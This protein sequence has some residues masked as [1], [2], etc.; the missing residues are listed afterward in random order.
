MMNYHKMLLRQ[1]KKIGLDR[2]TTP[3]DINKWQELVDIV[4]Q[5]YY[6]HDQDR[7]LIERSLDISSQ[8]MHVL[9][10]KLESAH[11]LVRFGYVCY[12]VA[13]KKITM[14]KHAYLMFG[15]DAEY[16]I[17][18]LNDLYLTVHIDQRKLFIQFIDDVIN[19]QKIG[20]CEIQIKDS[21]HG[22]IYKWYRIV[23]KP[24]M[25]D[26]SSAVSGLFAVMLDITIK[27]AA[28]AELANLQQELILSARQ[29]GMTD[30]ATSMLH[31]VGNILNSANVSIELINEN[32]NDPII[33]NLSSLKELIENH[34]DNLED[35]FTCDEKGK[36][37]PQYFMALADKINDLHKLIKYEV[38]N[39]DEKLK[40]IKDIT[41][42]QKDISG[43]AD[44]NEKVFIKQT[45]DSAIMM[46]DPNLN[47]NKIKIIRDY[48]N[49]ISI[50]SDRAKI[51]QILV[52][53]IKNAEDALL[54]SDR[55][56]KTLWITCKVI[57]DHV[58][59][60]I[61]DNGCGISHENLKKIYI[62]GFTTKKHG[63]GFG[64]HSASIVATELGG[65][66]TA[67]SDGI[68]KGSCFT[69]ILP[70]DRFSRGEKNDSKIEFENH[71]H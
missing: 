27:K 42:M 57:L 11:E 71:S 19:S 36:L 58:Q 20:E 3:N 55:Q 7:N 8:E 62:Y 26:D 66:L 56:E 48:A 61:K 15:C 68:D 38:A 10:S 53:F 5:S 9:H 60:S 44:M 17:D 32:L 31:N 6:I 25:K 54:S 13:I 24:T 21:P 12:D 41:A 33:N 37:F 2:D 30:V 64:L 46:S 14:S 51:L 28:D 70:I 22:D 49:D 47:I 16:A 4:N 18:N 43:S 1:L 23:V 65:H 63:H 67:V 59:I 52:N 35:F 39:L 29:A 45:I 40:H 34:R 69:L 50:K